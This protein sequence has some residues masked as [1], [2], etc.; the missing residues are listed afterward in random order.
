VLAIPQRGKLRS[1]G[2]GNNMAP[3]PPSASGEGYE[4]SKQSSVLA[5][6]VH[7]SYAA[8]TQAAAAALCLVR[9]T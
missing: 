7:S 9:V 8:G 3:R 2:W 4:M 6:S 5:A 1:E